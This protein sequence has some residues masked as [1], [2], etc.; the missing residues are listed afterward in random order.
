MECFV[1]GLAQVRWLVLSG[2]GPGEASA[3]PPATGQQV[4]WLAGLEKK[5]KKS[6]EEA[7]PG[8]LDKGNVLVY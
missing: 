5:R 6:P 4:G 1:L 2:P 8:I 3:L 7:N